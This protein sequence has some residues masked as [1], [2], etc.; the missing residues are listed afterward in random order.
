MDNMSRLAFLLIAWGLHAQTGLPARLEA[1]VAERAAD[2]GFM[3]AVLIAKDGKVLLEK[4][5]GLANVEWDVPNTP[6]TKFRLGSITKQF[7]ATA[8]LQLVESGQ[9]A[10][11]DPVKKYVP[12]APD[13]WNAITVHHL[14]NHT[15]G[16]PSYTDMPA[17]A[18]PAFRRTPLKP[19]EIG[20]LSK[21]KP[22][23]FQPG[24][25][26]RYNNTGYV[27]LGH[28]VESVSGMKYDAYLE[29]NVLGP[30]EMKDSGYDW[31]RPVLRKRADGY[32][33]NRDR[34]RYTNADFLDMSLPH[35]AGSLYS[36]VGDLYKW[37][38]A[39]LAGKLLSKESYEKMFTPG[40]NNYAY[41]WAVE[42]ADGRK[43]LGHGGGIFGFSTMILR[44]G[45]GDAVIIA[46]SNVENG[47][48]AGLARQLRTALIA[49]SPKN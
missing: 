10:L 40:R 12:E 18:T 42:E 8:V 23:L 17:F 49:Q 48:A 44:A 5:V 30:L 32:G 34:K 19:L 45:D 26:Y 24:E 29:K 47:D 1:I 38:Q 33:F 37:H 11:A 28:I 46:L 4:G 27:L 43:W 39:I 9:V 13:T 35:A 36:T 25:G 21:D 3:G 31:T 16:I 2:R 6:D 22:L 7:T 14:L 15:S 20:M 41:G